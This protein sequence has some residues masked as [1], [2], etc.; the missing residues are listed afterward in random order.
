MPPNLSDCQSTHKSHKSQPSLLY[1]SFWSPSPNERIN[2]HLAPPSSIPTTTSATHG[3]KLFNHQ[4]NNVRNTQPYTWQSEK[5]GNVGDLNPYVHED[6]SKKQARTCTNTTIQ[7]HGEEKLSKVTQPPNAC[8][9]YSTLSRCNERRGNKQHNENIAAVRAPIQR[10]AKT[11]LRVVSDGMAAAKQISQTRDSKE[12]AA[13]DFYRLSRRDVGET[14]RLPPNRI[15]ME[16]LSERRVIYCDGDT[17]AT[18]STAHRLDFSG[19]IPMPFTSTSVSIVQPQPHVSVSLT[20]N[21]PNSSASAQYLRASRSHL[22]LNGAS[23]A[24]GASIGRGDLDCCKLREDS[25]IIDV[26]SMDYSEHNNSNDVVDECRRRDAENDQNRANAIEEIG[27]ECA[28]SD[29]KCSQSTDNC[30]TKATKCGPLLNADNLIIT[31]AIE[32]LSMAASDSTPGK[33]KLSDDIVTMREKRR[34]ERRDRRLARTRTANGT[35]LSSSTNEIL[36]D[37]I[38]NHLPPP[39]DDVTPEQ[40]QQQQQA[41]PSVVSTVPVEDN[42]YAF[43]LPLVRR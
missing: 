19:D 32:N 9:S 2:T 40:Q 11:L 30:S 27:V 34:R 36:P 28:N 22:S 26:E 23:F 3:D 8:R 1:D 38:N 31:S 10:E 39:Y 25:T 24:A 17:P 20:N 6:S 14:Y 18:P 7:Q 4:R 12:N 42:R 16:H 15:R 35:S 21:Y 29:V 37:I 13:L 41:V 43:S 5:A 33:A